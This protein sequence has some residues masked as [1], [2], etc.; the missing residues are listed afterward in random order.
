MD[1]KHAD[2]VYCHDVVWKVDLN[3]GTWKPLSTCWRATKPNMVRETNDL[4]VITAKNGHQFGWGIVNY[5]SVLYMRVGDVFKPILC[6]ID[7]LKDNPYVSWPLYAL[8]ADHQKYPDGTYVWQDAN[9]DQTIQ[10][11]ELLKLPGRAESVFNIVDADLNLCPVPVSC[12]ALSASR[13][14][15][16]LRLQQARAVSFSHLE[17]AGGRSPRRQC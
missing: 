3:K 13:K 5:S 1:A 15:A 12:S 7:V 17:C 14:T 8:F 10:P 11:E 2:E 6:G 4:N 16:D 9:N